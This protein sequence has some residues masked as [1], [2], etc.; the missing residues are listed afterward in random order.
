M[1]LFLVQLASGCHSCWR[2][3]RRWDEHLHAGTAKRYSDPKV[4]AP[5]SGQGDG[6]G[7]GLRY[8]MRSRCT[9][10]TPPCGVSLSR[11]CYLFSSCFQLLAKLACNCR[12][13]ETF[14]LGLIF[15]TYLSWTNLSWI[16]KAIA[17]LHKNGVVHGHLC[18]A[19]G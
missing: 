17:Y 15:I 14:V 10:A 6:I 7:S 19:A 9:E 2:K 3:A 11:S 12:C 8:R 13:A 18:P 5:R 16:C 1:P 4:Q